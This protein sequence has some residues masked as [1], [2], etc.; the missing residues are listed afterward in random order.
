MITWVNICL[1]FGMA[2][3]Q[4]SLIFGAPLGEYVLGG[5]HKVLPPNMRV[6]SGLYAGIFIIVG[7]SFMQVTGNMA[8]IFNMTFM[9][10]ILI[11][12]T[13]FLAY[14]IIGNGFLTKSK[15]EKYVM[16]PIS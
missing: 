5:K 6:I 14:A 8:M 13:L 4:L 2:L 12:Y 11:I 3:L 10:V 9:R 16:T 1:A 15:K 7:L